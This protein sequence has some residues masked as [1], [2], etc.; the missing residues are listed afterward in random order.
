MSRRMRAVL[1]LGGLAGAPAFI[2]ACGG[3][4]TTVGADAGV[5]DGGGDVA[6]HEPK[7]HRSL[8]TACPQGR[9]AGTPSPQAPVECHTDPE[10]DGGT[11]GRCM[12]PKGGPF[13]NYCSYDECFQDSTCTAGQVCACRASATDNAANL[14]TSGGNCRVD[15]DCAGGYCSPSPASQVSGC[16]FAY[17]CHTAS[18]P[19]LDDSQ[20]PGS[21]PLCAFDLTAKHWACSTDCPPPP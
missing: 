16:N 19:C 4:V 9:G 10:C 6:V 11:N 17:F 8:A 13:M 18:D 3:V 2:W 5:A 21:S 15:S 14:C 7:N 20:C 1:L 12:P